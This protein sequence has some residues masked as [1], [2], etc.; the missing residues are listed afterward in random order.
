MKNKKNR[1]AMKHGLHR[2]EWADFQGVWI[3]LMKTNIL[4]WS[5][6]KRLSE[7]M[8]PKDKKKT[9]FFWLSS[10]GGFKL[11]LKSWANKL[12][13]DIDK[14]NQHKKCNY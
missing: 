11:V 8:F 14:G 6:K 12:L 5:T 10:A 4:P 7:G 1:K 13:N 3:N 9:W 2:R